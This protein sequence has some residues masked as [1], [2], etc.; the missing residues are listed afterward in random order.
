MFDENQFRLYV[1]RN[2]VEPSSQRLTA[3]PQG[4]ANTCRLELHSLLTLTSEG[5]L[6]SPT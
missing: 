3:S 6:A 5:R 2:E 1:L 4:G